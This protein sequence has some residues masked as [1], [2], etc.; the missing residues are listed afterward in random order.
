[1]DK[2]LAKYVKIA[3]V[4]SA[5]ILELDKSVKNMMFMTNLDDQYMDKSDNEEDEKDDV[6]DI[7][8]GDE[9]VNYL[10]NGLNYDDDNDDE[11]DD[12]NDKESEILQ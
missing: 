10:N 7:Y 3:E 9:L 5:C 2:L 1:M 4:D 8:L 12:D 11:E 6:V